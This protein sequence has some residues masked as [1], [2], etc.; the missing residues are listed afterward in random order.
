MWTRKRSTTIGCWTTRRCRTTSASTRVPSR[1]N[2]PKTMAPS[3]ETYQ[4]VETVTAIAG[5]TRTKESRWEFKV[6]LHPSRNLC[7]RRL[8]SN[9]HRSPPLSRSRLLIPL[10]S[11]PKL[12]LSA[13]PLLIQSTPI[14]KRSYSARHPRTQCS[15]TTA[16]AVHCALPVAPRVE[17]R[18]LYISIRP[19]RGSVAYRRQLATHSELRHRVCPAAPLPPPSPGN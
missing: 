2:S 4:P 6:Q 7:S 12:D 8:P 10:R 1:R 18:A 5:K 14:R 16:R 13:T 9:S 19:T 17:V 11:T 15:A 3:A